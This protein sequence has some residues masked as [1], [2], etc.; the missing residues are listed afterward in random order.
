M[1]ALGPEVG[2]IISGFV[3][4]ASWRWTFWSALIISGSGL[5]VMLLLPE[6][7]APVLAQRSQDYTESVRHELQTTSE[8]PKKQR[9]LVFGRPFLM[10]VREPILL[11]TSLYL[12]LAYPLIFQ[13]LVE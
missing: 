3:S 7:Y 11:M 1:T 9:I 4:L 10:V 2:P 12:A 13:G 6:T 8:S 5:P